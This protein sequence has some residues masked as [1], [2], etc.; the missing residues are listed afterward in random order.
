M[1]KTFKYSI[2]VL[3]FLGLMLVSQ[4]QLHA[5]M[6]D[7]N[8]LM[9]NSKESRGMWLTEELRDKLHAQFENLTEE[10]KV[11]REQR[12]EEHRNE[13]DAFFGMSREE[14][15]EQRRN[16]TPMSDILEGRGISYE[17]AQVFLNEKMNGRYEHITETHE[18]TTEESQTL[19][20]KLTERVQTMLDRW[21]N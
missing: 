13:N 20:E 7:Q 6:E 10:Q 17:D 1:K 8:P 2:P 18:L 11:L 19:L 9:G 21:F 15:R 12:R 14:I 16:G 4:T 3:S 5:Y